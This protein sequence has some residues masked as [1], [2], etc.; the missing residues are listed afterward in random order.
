MQD[1]I[2]K[3]LKAYFSKGFRKKLKKEASLQGV[4]ARLAAK[5][6]KLNGKLAVATEED[7]VKLLQKQIKV[8]HAQRKKAER[9]IED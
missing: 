1:E 8:L 4:I 6:Q 7:E 2:I 9:L 5:E 3:K